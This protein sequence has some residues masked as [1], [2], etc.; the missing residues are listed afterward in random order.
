MSLHIVHPETREGQAYRLIQDTERS[1][2]DLNN[3]L[4]KAKQVLKTI[5]EYEKRKTGSNAGRKNALTM[6]MQ[7]ANNVRNSM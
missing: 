5:D 1:K 2:T 7:N 6:A 4:L 3:D